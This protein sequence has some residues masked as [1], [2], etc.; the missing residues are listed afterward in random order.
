MDKCKMKSKT[1]DIIAFILIISLVF[2][3][4]LTGCSKDQGHA[5]ENQSGSGKQ[6]NK[7]TVVDYLGR[8]VEV[9][10][11]VEK[12]GCL[13]AFSG[14]VAAMLGEG[15]KIAAVVDGLKRDKL[16]GELVPEIKNA[17][18]P[19]TSGAINIE[20]LLKA[21]PDVV[22]VKSDTA[23]NK[24]ETEKLDKSRIPYLV[25]DYKN[26][27]EQQYII[28][29]IGKAIGAYEKAKKYTEYYQASIEYVRK[30]TADIPA[31]RRVRVY[32]SVNEATR[33]DNKDTLPADWMQAVGVINVSVDQNLK[34]LEDKYFAS[35][36]QIFLWD[37]DIIMANELGVADYIMNNSQWHTLRAVKSKKVYQMPN[38]IS[39]WGHPGSLETPLA[40]LWAAKTVYPEKF[41]DLDIK[42]E[43]KKYYKEFFNLDLTD[44]TVSQILS[45]NGM[46]I[47]KGKM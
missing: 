6:E 20:E 4:A 10:E 16:M 34:L 28:E 27:K 1:A 8:K 12:I 19:V 31:N 38:G 36:E 26:M 43:T 35:L 45:G 25:V 11:K 23:G 3:L 2:V 22:F 46:R 21:K 7:I 37:P 15:S 24:G 5:S 29:M 39:R 9:P 42:L 13:Y 17:A 40:L 30:R 44:E 47:S 18:V 14:H 41:A 33:T 32:H